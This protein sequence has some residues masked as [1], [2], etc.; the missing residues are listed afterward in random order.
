[1]NDG[2]NDGDESDRL[3]ITWDLA[4]GTTRADDP[5]ADRSAADVVN[6]A[7]DDGPLALRDADRL[8]CRVPEDIVALRAA[9]PALA[10]G[11]AARRPRSVHRGVRRGP[12]RDGHVTRRLVPVDPFVVRQ[13]RRD[14]PRRQR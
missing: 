7:P 1:M 12:A 14:L 4:T 11:V 6:R 9:D 3:T 2:V 8:W 13:P 5:T 10:L